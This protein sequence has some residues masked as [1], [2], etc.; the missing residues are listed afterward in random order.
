MH[1]RRLKTRPSSHW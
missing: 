1:K